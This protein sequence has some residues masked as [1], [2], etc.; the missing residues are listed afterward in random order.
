[1]SKRLTTGCHWFPLRISISGQWILY[2]IYTRSSVI[3]NLSKL[4]IKKVNF[5]D[6]LFMKLFSSSAT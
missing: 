5:P 2:A 4:Y 1:M 6:E 3:G